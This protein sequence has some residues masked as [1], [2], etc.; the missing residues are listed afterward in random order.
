[1]YKN[2]MVPLD[3][4]ELA[5]CVLPHVET[6]AQGRNV[7]ILTLVRVV[8]PL[9][10]YGGVDSRLTPEGR[11]QLEQDAINIAKKYLSKIARRLAKTKVPVQSE[12]VYGQIVEKLID[13][14]AENNIDLIVL[15]THG[16][17]GISRWVWGSVTDRLLRASCTPILMV[18]GPG[19][20][21]GI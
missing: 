14:A 12:V 16:R 8:E 6:V 15:S 5:E 10:M 1:M 2:I 20:F 19:C 4:S 18:R 17:S 11:Q 9:H 21:A 13:Y 7:K 3:G